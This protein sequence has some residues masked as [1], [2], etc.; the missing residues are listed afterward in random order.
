MRRM[1]MTCFVAGMTIAMLINLDS[2]NAQAPV[3]F[4]VI[5]I[6]PWTQASGCDVADMDGDGDMDVVYS[7]ESG[8][9]SWYENTAG[10]GSAFTEHPVQ[11]NN[12][13]EGYWYQSWSVFAADMDGDGDNDIVGGTGHFENG[14]AVYEVTLWRN[15]GGGSFTRE[16]VGEG[17]TS[18]GLPLVL[19]WA[20]PGDQNGDGDLDI[21]VCDYDSVVWYENNGTGGFTLH[22]LDD[23]LYGARGADF[24]DVDGDG[25]KEIVAAS[26]YLEKVVYYSAAGGGPVDILNVPGAFCV[27]VLDGDGDGDDD[28]AATGA[29]IGVYYLDNTGGSFSSTLIDP[30]GG[31]YSVRIADIDGDGAQDLVCSHS[32]TWY[33]NNG[34]GSGWSTWYLPVDDGWAAGVGDID[35][36]GDVDIATS[37]F[38][39]WGMGNLIWLG[40]GEDDA[41]YDPYGGYGGGY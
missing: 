9:M 27:S 35:G 23:D 22:E 25:S 10:D 16:Y 18:D 3:D 30:S 40:N 28:V 19:Y 20:K 34:T 6:D 36:D 39:S 15:S 37:P 13:A 32:G 21:A 41:I 38:F 11:L 1:R 26:Y 31:G 8:W 33:Q 24:A 5:D 17:H 29:G 14:Q 12:D 4:G 7:V 2:A